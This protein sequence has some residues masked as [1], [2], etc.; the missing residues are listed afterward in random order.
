MRQAKAVDAEI[1]RGRLRGP[2][3]GIPYGAK[4]LLSVAGQITTWGARPMPA[5]V[6]DYNATVIQ[7][8]EAPARC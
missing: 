2:L 8:L 4:D 1:K 6:F 7:K 5:Q 3:Q